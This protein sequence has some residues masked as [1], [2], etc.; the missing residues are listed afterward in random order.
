M[1]KF[2]EGQKVGIPDRIPG[3]SSLLWGR[4]G[5][6]TFVGSPMTSMP[7]GEAAEQQYMVRFDGENED[8]NVSESWLEPAD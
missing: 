3:A 1:T 2:H 4:V 6:V 7:S 8:R 5:T